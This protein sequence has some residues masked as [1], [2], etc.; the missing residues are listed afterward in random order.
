VRSSILASKIKLTVFEI[1]TVL[2][3]CMGVNQECTNPRRQVAGAAKI[4][5]DGA[6]YVRS[7]VCNCVVSPLWRLEFCCDA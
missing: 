6:F 5:I 1:I 3:L 2:I 7:S 4:S